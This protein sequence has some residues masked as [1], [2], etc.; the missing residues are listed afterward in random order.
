MTVRSNNLLKKLDVGQCA[1]L[2]I[3]AFD[4]GPSDPRNLLVIVL[5]YENELYT[6]GTKTGRLAAKYTAA[7]L[8]PI[9]ERLL[10]SEDVPNVEIPLR[11]AVGKYTRGQGYQKCMCKTVCRSGFKKIGSSF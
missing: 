11:T 1:T 9:Q 8:E 4:L 3:P 10:S 2:K 6:L 7:D 5:G